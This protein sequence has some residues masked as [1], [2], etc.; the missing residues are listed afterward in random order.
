MKHQYFGDINDYRKYGLLRALSQA[1]GLPLG[2]CWLLTAPDARPDGEF[3]NYLEQPQRWRHHDP[4]LYDALQRLQEP[5]VARSVSHAEAWGLLPG[6]GYYADLLEDPLAQRNDYFGRAWKTLAHCPLLFLDPD[7]G[8]EV[9][10][11][12][13]GSR[14][15]SKYLY[16]VEVEEAYRRG[17]SLVI[18]QHWPRQERA[19]YTRRLAQECVDRLGAPLVD[20]FATAHVLFLLVARPEHAPGFERAHELILQRWAGQVTPMAH[21]RSGTMSPLPAAEPS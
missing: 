1:S 20:S 15:S 2:V 3:R 11:T 21:V 9:K 19:A 10:S 8:L 6:A 14:D 13:R 17:H 7:N 4:E 12:R 18:Y 16:W 5:G